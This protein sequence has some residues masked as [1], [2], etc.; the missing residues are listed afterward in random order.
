MIAQGRYCWAFVWIETVDFS[1]QCKACTY[2]WT[3]STIIDRYHDPHEWVVTDSHGHGYAHGGSAALAAGEC[4]CRCAPPI[5]NL[6]M[7][8]SA[9]SLSARRSRYGRT[10]GVTATSREFT[11]RLRPWLRARRSTA[12]GDGSF[13]SSSNKNSLNIF[14]TIPISYMYFPELKRSK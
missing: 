6:S 4:V 5:L 2:R 3:F 9:A 7:Q 14:G 10:S 11:A 8:T 13:Q 1:R 12:F